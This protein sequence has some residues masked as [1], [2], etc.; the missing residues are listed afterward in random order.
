MAAG[1]LQ[2]LLL[3][4]IAVTLARLC[5]IWETDAAFS[6]AG[7]MIDTFESYVW[8]PALVKSNAVTA[9][10]EAACL[11]LSVDETVTN[12]RSE[13]RPCTWDPQ[14]PDC[15]CWSSSCADWAA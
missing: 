7:G 15:P 11:V 6:T 8:E 4:H 14:Q 12:P 3:R 2:L 10:T 5:N 9:A 13:V 1:L